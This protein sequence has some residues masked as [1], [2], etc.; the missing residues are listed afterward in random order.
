MERQIVKLYGDIIKN[1][2]IAINISRT[3]P[4]GHPSLIPILQR[5]K[6]LLKEIPVEEESISL[7]VIEDVIMIKDYR[8]ESKKLPIVKS[9]VHRFNQLGIKSIT[10]NVTVSDTDLWSFF[11]AMSATA[12]DISDY[13]DITAL[14]KAKGITGIRVNKYRVGVIS[15]DEEI[16]EINWENFLESLMVSE[17][18]VSEE[19]QVKE[20]SKFLT[21]LG[22]TGSESV[23]V[24][25]SKIVGGLEKL[26]LIIA[27]QY[28]EERW[29]EYSIIFSRILSV[30]SP[31]IKKNIIKYKTEN[32]KLAVL[33][34]SLIPTMSDEDII[35]IVSAKAREKGANAEEEIIDILKYV[36][37]TRLPDILS[38]L[39]MN[40]PELNFEKIVARL[41]NELKIKKGTESA[42]K[43]ISKNLETE[44]RRF[45]PQLRDPSREIRMKAI[46]ELLQYSDKII[47]TGDNNLFRLLVDRFDTMADAETD[48]TTFKKVIDALKLLYQKASAIENNELVQFISK[49]FGKH[50]VRKEAGLLERKKIVIKAISELKDK[51]YIPE[52]VSLLWDPGTFAEARE[53]LI[54]LSEFSYPILLDSL[55]ETEDYTVRK[56]II[57]ILVKMGEK[58]VPEI[59][60]FLND[61][62][63]YI[64]R[65]GLFLLGEMR[66]ASAIDEIGKLIND[67]KEQVQLEAVIAL[68]KINDPKT[69]KYFKKALNSKY[70][71]VVLKAMGY[72]EKEDVQHKLNQIREWLKKRKG[73][74]NKKEEK[75]RQ[76]IIQIL[77]K[78][79]GDAVIP[80]LLEV[81]NEG[82]LFKANLLLP[83]KEAALNA[84]AEIGTEKAINTLTQATRHRDRFISTTARTI[85]KRYEKKTSE[86]VPE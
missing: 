5:L 30:L 45:F 60:K 76:E 50:L 57:N 41:M 46:E 27:D 49:K 67:E 36:T 86:T 26:A 11:S 79:G 4:Q 21:N 47:D 14:I 84:L 32:K 25:S 2:G 6:I 13:G 24:Q 35:E 58:A 85:L 55:K 51:N 66:I 70:P 31:T 63:W 40:V 15:T 16:K 19:E 74:P 62:M 69:K 48:I 28:G 42:N 56:K 83:T 65:N 71:R 81:L 37:G 43:F 9:L 8:F 33:I 68:G 12:A 38:T 77:G 78:L 75:F 52:L 3:Y 82:A 17:A 39:R 1:I 80:D 72:L 61:K 29:G 18:A 23:D 7:V 59:L 73:I 64:R 54:S 20:L 34:R 10:I 44:I 22:I 53:A